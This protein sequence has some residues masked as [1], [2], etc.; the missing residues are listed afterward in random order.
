MRLVVVSSP[1]ARS[2]LHWSHAA[3]VVVAGALAAAGHDVVWFAVARPGQVLPTPPGGVELR[4]LSVPVRR[5]DAVA[6]DSEHGELEQAL[7]RS[8]REQPAAAV[9]HVGA[10]ARGSPNVAWLAERMGSGAYAVVRAAE[11]VCH[12]G[13]LVARDG[14]PCS[15]FNDPARCRRCCA[16]GFWRT[17]RA[18]A[19]RNRGDLL[20]GS[21][22]AAEAVFVTDPADVATL[23]AFGVPPASL[24]P[25][26]DLA[27]IAARLLAG[28]VAGLAA[29]G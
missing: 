12:R 14:A 29:R 27:A 22:L 23:T 19:F 10:G 4:G 28:P 8:L 11:V 6:A 15:T 17:P 25:M 5:L 9:V 1:G 24:V 21:L 7:A 16:G 20:A 3:A 26:P 18:D 13:D 2:E